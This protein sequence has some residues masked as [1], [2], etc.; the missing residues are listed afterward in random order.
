MKAI[1][2]LFL[3]IVIVLLLTPIASIAS[4]IKASAT[5]TN[6]S[7]V[8]GQQITVPVTIDLADLPERLGSFT[9][10]LHWDAQLLKYVNYNAGST[11]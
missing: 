10:E 6:S 11:D 5:P 7:V 2:C 8:N 3:I 9:A 4:I 1:K